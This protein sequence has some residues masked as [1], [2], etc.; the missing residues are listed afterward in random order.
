MSFCT[1]G[2]LWLYDRKTDRFRR[3]QPRNVAAITRD[4]TVLTDDGRQDTIL[5][6]QLAVIDGGGAAIIKKFRVGTP[7]SRKERD[8]FAWYLGFLFARVPG[9]TRFLDETWT[10]ATGA[11]TR[12]SQVDELFAHATSPYD[13][14]DAGEN[15]MRSFLADCGAVRVNQNE[16]MVVV[17]Q[18]AKLMCETFCEM[19]W[20]IAHSDDNDQFT[21]TDNPI[22][23]DPEAYTF[24][25]AP[26]CALLMFPTSEHLVKVTHERMASRNVHYL[27]VRTARL[28][29]RFVMGRDDNY[30]RHVV[31][32][33]TI[34]GS[35]PPPISQPFRLP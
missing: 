17:S 23:W 32:E 3:D 28:C 8:G 9:F 16:R 21:T 20:V 6:Q 25:I 2:K 33:A 15:S 11:E 1:D 31:N 26:D 13:R 19:D 18:T 30:L 29:E 14:S 7:I 4:Y 10:V 5:E 12:P 35:A 27:N 22:T 34:R 24:P